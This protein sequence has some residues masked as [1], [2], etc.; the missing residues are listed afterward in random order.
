MTFEF[1]GGCVFFQLAEVQINK[2]Q[3][4][5]NFSQ[6][7]KQNSTPTP[8]RKKEKKKYINKQNYIYLT[9]KSFSHALSILR[10]EKYVNG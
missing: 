4:N 5:V 1:K 10:A 6:V 2:H 7:T 8:L 3:Q 9:V